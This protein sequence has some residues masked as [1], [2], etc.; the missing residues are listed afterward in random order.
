MFRKPIC[1]AAVF[2]K[3]KLAKKLK[4]EGPERKRGKKTKRQMSGEERR[5]EERNEEESGPQRV[6]SEVLVFLN[7]EITKEEYVQELKSIILNECQS[8]ESVNLA[9]AW[10][11]RIDKDEFSDLEKLRQS[12]VEL[13]ECK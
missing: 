13:N 12:I 5:E 10:L 3:R 6:G 1:A 8:I 11:K 2:L 4:A 7:R 9:N